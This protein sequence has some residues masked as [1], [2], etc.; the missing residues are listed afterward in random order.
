MK[1]LGLLLCA[2]S[3]MV[4]AGCGAIASQLKGLP[5][6]DARV[7]VEVNK[8]LKKLSEKGAIET[9]VAVYENIKSVATK[10]VRMLDNYT[11]LNNAFVLEVNSNDIESIKSVPGVK[12]VTVD[13]LHWEREINND[14]Y[15]TLDGGDA[16]DAIDESKN[17]SAETMFLPEDNN[18]GEGTI[19]AILD[20]EFHFRAS[21]KERVNGQ[22]VS[23]EEWHHEVFNPLD[24]SV[25]VR[26]TFESMRAVQGLNA[27]FDPV[28]IKPAGQ[29]GSGYLN[30]KVPFYYD[31]GGESFA[32]GKRGPKKHD[33]HS[34]LSYHGSHVSSI[35]A[36]NA[37]QY[38][39]IAPKAQLALMKV[40]TDYNAKGIGEKIGLSNRT[41]AYDSA[42]LEALEDCIRL[43]VDGIN[44]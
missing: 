11:V 10:N 22:V 39:G 44:M 34:D 36:A 4:L 40:F 27:S 35:T 33:V 31:Y 37:P 29:E 12:S 6:R 26:Y 38:K 14:S 30:N 13:K 1:K 16:G 5:E 32:Y 23:H 20:N 43:K 9:Q 18:E 24:D 28:K 17:I 41:G 25:A 19:V 42:I 8:D 3:A 21:Y 2:T 7:I 15:I